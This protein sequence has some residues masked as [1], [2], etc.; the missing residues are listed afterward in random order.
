M[1]ALNFKKRFAADVAAFRK[2]QSVRAKRSDGRNP[3]VGQI[4]YLY[5]GQRTKTC[6]KLGEAVCLSVDQITITWTGVNINGVW[7]SKQEEEAFA[8]ADGFESAGDLRMFFNLEQ[9]SLPVED[10]LLFKW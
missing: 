1:P 9:D 8:R 2:R 3:R 10:A 7:L 5:T 4:L 6:R